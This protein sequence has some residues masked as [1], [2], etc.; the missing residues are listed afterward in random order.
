M[1]MSRASLAG[2]AGPGEGG[3]LPLDHLQLHL[4][5]EK[6]RDQVSVYQDYDL[7]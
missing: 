2:G 3:C 7:S 1:L 6:V 5:V 4:E